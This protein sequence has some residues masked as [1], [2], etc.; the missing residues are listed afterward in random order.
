MRGREQSPRHT[1]GAPP[2]LLSP[3]GKTLSLPQA[4]PAGQN[5]RSIQARPSLHLTDKQDRPD[6]PWHRAGHAGNGVPHPYPSWL[7]GKAAGQLSSLDGDTSTCDRTNSKSCCLGHGLSARR[8]QWEPCLAWP[9]SQAAGTEAALTGQLGEP[10]TVK[11]SQA[12]H[13]REGRQAG[14]PRNTPA[15]SRPRLAT[16]HAL[17]LNTAVAAWERGLPGRRAAAPLTHPTPPLAQQQ[18]SGPNF[19][20]TLWAASAL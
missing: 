1:P 2:E 9:P 16:A 7:H 18:G 3:S 13:Q 6:G 20:T 12:A 15:R 5:P 4:Y 17:G 11:A 8:G 10:G 19:N 14:T